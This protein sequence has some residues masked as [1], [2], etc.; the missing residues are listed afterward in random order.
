MRT[1]TLPSGHVVPVLGQGTWHLGEEPRRRAD[2]LAA[3]RLGIELGM[4]LI[5]TAEMYLGAE[6]L[7][8]EA[9]AGQRDRCFVID[10]VVPNHATRSGTI[11]ACEASLRRLDTEWIDLYL[12]HWRGAVELEP[13]LEAFAELMATG[14]IRAW[15]VSNFDVADLLDL[16]G[17]TDQVPATDE[18]LYNLAHRGIEWDLVPWCRRRGIPV[19]AYSP[20]EEGTLLRHPA[21]R[22][23]AARHAATPA[24]IA[25]AWVLRHP[26]VITI[27]K[28]SSR[29][30][31]RENH[32][33]LELHL[34]PE[35]LAELDRAFAP[36]RRKV[37]LDVL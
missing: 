32:A 27:P 36:P 20:F 22:A 31:V 4:T 5:D 18:V 25:L 28:A 37:P 33:A 2:E 16:V 35:D 9:I 23:V 1:V 26:D 14:K 8:R 12:L 19:I 21:L 30:H 10:K 7:V 6:D 11:A 3:L 17:L 24:Q 13:T 34:T 29:A 15:G